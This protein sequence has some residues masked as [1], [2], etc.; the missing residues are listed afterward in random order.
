MV[1]P[2]N[3]QQRAL[4]EV[5][6]GAAARLDAGEPD[7]ALKVLNSRGGFALENPV[8]KNILGEIRLQ[9]GNAAEALRAFDAAVKLAPSFAEAHANRGAALLDLGRLMEA[10]EAERR[11]LRYRP[12]YPVANFNR[13]IVLAALKRTDEAIAAFSDALKERPDYAEAQLNRGM[14]LLEATIVPETANSAPWKAEIEKLGS[15]LEG[16]VDAT[17]GNFK[18]DIDRLNELGVA[19]H[20]VSESFRVQFKKLQDTLTQVS[21]KSRSDYLNLERLFRYLIDAIRARDAEAQVKDAE[22]LVCSLGEKLIL[23]TAY[24]DSKAWLADYQIWHDN[25][26]AI[27]QA[28]ISL[29]VEGYTAF[30][31]IQRRDLEK[32]A[33]MPPKEHGADEI[34]I[35]YKTVCLAQRRYRDGRDQ[36]F[37]YFAAKAA[38]PS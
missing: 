9:Q 38:L 16:Y 11:A 19:Q 15:A 17:R 7:E 13:G 34:I 20:E 10:L 30:L 27:D 3:P 5:L 35:P 33:E 29:G 14:A 18:S 8:G 31:N 37:R 12:K 22:K 4:Q 2:L 6:S 28:V 21:T 23:G 32:C 26:A 24:T 25:L 1:L 36:L